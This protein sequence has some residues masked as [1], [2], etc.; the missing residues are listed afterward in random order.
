MEQGHKGDIQSKLDEAKEC[1]NL[2]SAYLDNLKDKAYIYAE[3]AL[4][5]EEVDQMLSELFPIDEKEDSDRKRANVQKVKNEYQIAYMM[6][7]I[8]QYRDTAWG[9]INAMSDMLTHTQPIRNTKNYQENRWGLVMGG[10]PVFDKFVK[11][12]ND[13]VSV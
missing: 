8:K 13:R 6:P 4:Y 1:L 9:A 7:D 2:A 11:M 12:I 10:H 3:S 5:K